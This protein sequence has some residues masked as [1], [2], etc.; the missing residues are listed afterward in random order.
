MEEDATFFV[1]SAD[2]FGKGEPIPPNSQQVPFRVK[3]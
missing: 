1:Y 2:M 3:S